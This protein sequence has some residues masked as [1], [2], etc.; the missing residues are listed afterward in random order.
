MT[1]LPQKSHWL[2]PITAAV[3]LAGV[4]TFVFWPLFPVGG[5]FGKAAAKRDMANGQFKIYTQ[6]SDFGWRKE[7]KENVR[8]KYGIEIG[9]RGLSCFVS[10]YR[11]TYDAAY[12]A[13]QSA[14][15]L[16]QFGR[17]VVREEMLLA[18]Q[19]R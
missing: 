3:V 1:I 5:P 6:M 17:D 11:S 9:G 7:W 14:R 19:K 18:A 13:E 8:E 16:R 15:I 12:N 2:A 10:E 4:L